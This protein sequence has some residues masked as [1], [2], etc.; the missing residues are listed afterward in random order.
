[1]VA[2]RASIHPPPATEESIIQYVCV[3]PTV[4]RLIQYTPFVFVP[5]R[6]LIYVALGAAWAEVD[7]SRGSVGVGTAVGFVVV[8]V[9]VPEPVNKAGPSEDKF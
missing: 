8:K 1:V 7:P 9:A 4:G 5:V 6:F 2:L 3:G